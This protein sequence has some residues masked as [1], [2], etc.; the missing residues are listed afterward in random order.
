MRVLISLMVLMSCALDICA[1]DSRQSPPIRL[2]IDLTQMGYRPAGPVHYSDKEVFRN[3][4]LLM[5][6]D[7]RRL[8]FVS[9][10]VL[11]LYFNHPPERNNEAPLTTYPM[12][13]FFVS[14]DSAKLIDHRTWDTLKRQWFNDSYD[15][16]S[17][18]LEVRTGFL[19]DA[20]AKLELY[21]PD[22]KLVKT[23]ELRRDAGMGMWSVEVA[24]GGDVIH[25]QPSEQTTQ[26]HRGSASYFTGAGETESTWLRSDSFEKIGTLHYFGG[27]H[28]ASHDSIVTKSAHCLDLEQGGKPTRHLA[29]ST[30]PASGVPTFL[31]DEEVLSVYDTGFSVLSTNGTEIWS[32]GDSEH[33]IHR[34]LMIGSERRSMNGARFA[35]SLTGYK[36]KAVFDNVPV[37][38]SPLH[39]LVA[40]D[41]RC[42]QRIFTVTP[43]QTLADFALSPEGRTLA[44][45][46][47]TTITVYTLP[48]AS[49]D[50]TSQ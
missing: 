32:A 37:A 4:K 34:A 30:L 11:A 31:N 50:S 9:E 28:S 7:H 1:S 13:V 29:C 35:I 23:Y 26:I 43:T 41:G 45:L 49:C 27:I 48:K 24:P 18:I 33:G 40:Y 25:V 17:R 16:E 44:I 20:N 3:L 22:L 21:S 36:K 10:N 8:S 14:T 6:D 19:V 47:G 46:T 39:T 15:T 5:Q 2:K 12:E 42:R 38:H